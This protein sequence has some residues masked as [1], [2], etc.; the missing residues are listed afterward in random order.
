M[1][2][3]GCATC[4]WEPGPKVVGFTAILFSPT[5]LTSFLS[6]GGRV[7]SSA[8][9]HAPCHASY[10]RYGFGCNLTVRHLLVPGKLHFKFILNQVILRLFFSSV[11]VLT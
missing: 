8:H 6:V 11:V 7:Y 1:S 4:V 9:C 10:V 5:V 2:A 3:D